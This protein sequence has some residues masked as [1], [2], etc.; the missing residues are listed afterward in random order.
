[1]NEK[2][3][4]IAA[5]KESLTAGGVPASAPEVGK[6]MGV[7]NILGDQRRAVTLPSSAPHA[8][9]DLLRQGAQISRDRGINLDYAKVAD[10]A[11]DALAAL[12]AENEAIKGTFESYS[13]IVNDHASTIR[14]QAERIAELE[15]N[16]QV[17]EML[18]TH[19]RELAVK[20]G[21]R[22][23][24]L[25]AWKTKAKNLLT[26]TYG[27]VGPDHQFWDEKQPGTLESLQPRIE[28]LLKET[29]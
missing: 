18:V 20:R 15:K 10:Q 17:Y 24:S 12:K 23:A 9:I 19:W 1:M 29:P 14:Q 8:L 11:A 3:H 5:V 26:D 22:I 16:D 21:E 25:E 6:R 2:E 4:P 28:K 13:T 27:W 7:M